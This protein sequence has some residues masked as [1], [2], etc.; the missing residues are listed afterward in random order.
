MAKLTTFV[1]TMLVLIC[2]VRSHWTPE[3]NYSPESSAQIANA[4]KEKL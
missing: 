3:H 4:I 2:A 1:V